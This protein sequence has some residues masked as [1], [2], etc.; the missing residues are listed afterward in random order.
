MGHRRMLSMKI[1][2]RILNTHYDVTKD[3]EESG[4]CNRMRPSNLSKSKQVLEPRTPHSSGT[5]MWRKRK[6]FPIRSCFPLGRW[7]G[8]SH[9]LL[10]L[11][12]VLLNENMWCVWATIAIPITTCTTVPWEKYACPLPLHPNNNKKKIFC[13]CILLNTGT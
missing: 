7:E 4:L 8:V 2:G 1:K 12:F 6:I 3:A 9:I 13:S 11:A 10:C 5:G